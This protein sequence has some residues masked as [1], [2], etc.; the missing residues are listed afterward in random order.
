MFPKVKSLV[1]SI[2]NNC[3]LIETVFF[4]EIKNL[5]NTFINCCNT[6]KII[7]QITLVFKADKF[8]TR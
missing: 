3:I 6:G 5:S 7:L 4:Q 8:I 2:N 1:G